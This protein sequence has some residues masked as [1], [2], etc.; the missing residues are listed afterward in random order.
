MMLPTLKS[1]THSVWGHIVFIQAIYSAP[2]FALFL[3]WNYLD[4]TLTA[5]Q[6]A[7]LA[8]I[9]SGTGVLAAVVGWYAILQPLLLRKKAK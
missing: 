4:G 6:G 7:W 1:A 5:R 3:G 2:L 9:C 8:L